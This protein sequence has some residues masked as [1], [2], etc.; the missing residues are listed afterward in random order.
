MDAR[1]RREADGLSDLA[2]RRGVPAVADRL[3]DEVQDPP[4]PG[5]DVSH[6]R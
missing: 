1:G 2:D 5:G 3:G 4:L 6:G